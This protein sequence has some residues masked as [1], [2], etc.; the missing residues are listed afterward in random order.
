MRKRILHVYDTVR[1]ADTEYRRLLKE[2]AYRKNSTVGKHNSRTIL[3]DNEEHF[4]YT[5]QQIEKCHL[6]G[7][8]IDEYRGD[9]PHHLKPYLD[10]LIFRSNSE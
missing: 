1:R 10:H 6:D 5:T 8:L 4:F 7:Q 2:L 3:Y 9:V